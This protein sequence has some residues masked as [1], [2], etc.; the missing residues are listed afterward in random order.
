M[1]PVVVVAILAIAALAY[2]SSPLRSGESNR[3]EVVPRSLEEARGRKAA[4][5]GALLELDEDAAMGK[6]TLTDLERLRTQYEIEAVLALNELDEVQTEPVE[7]DAL[8][9][10]I[11]A[12]RE[13]MRCPS[14]GA[15]RP[16]GEPC[17]RC[18][19]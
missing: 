7:E 16:P 3:A 10:E 6:I 9:L 12:L 1:I 18:G 4:A 17:P 5:L 11:R 15:V 13:R 8:E 19:A 14:C 2:V